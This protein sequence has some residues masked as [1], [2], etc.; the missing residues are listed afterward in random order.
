MRDREGLTNHITTN[1]TPRNDPIQSTVSSLFY[2]LFQ[3]QHMLI[4]ML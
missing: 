4:I 2:E 3:K 1:A